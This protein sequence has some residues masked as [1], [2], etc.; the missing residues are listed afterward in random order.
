MSI[1]Q[2]GRND[3]LGVQCLRAVAALLVV[4]YHAVEQWTNHMP[5][6]PPGEYWPNGAAGVDIFFVISGLVMTISVQRSAGCPHAAWAFSKN[7]IIR[8]VPLYWII[9]TLKIVAVIAVPALVSR[10]TLDPFYVAG[11]YALLPVRDAVGIIR[12][13]LPV[14]W[15]LSYE[16]FFYILIAAALVIRVPIMRV[17]AP[18]L[19]A[20]AALAF[21]LPEGGFTNTI[22]VE[23]IF[24]I[25]IGNALPRLRNVPP[26]IAA[27]IGSIAFALLVT[28]PIG[29]A[30][31]R[32]LTWGLPAAGIVAATVSAELSLRRWLP[33]WLLAAGN[34]SYATYLTHGF[35][36]PAAFLLVRPVSANLA[37]MILVGLT[38]SAAVG[39]VTHRL[40]EQPLLLSLRSRRPVSTL[41]AAG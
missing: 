1:L 38:V 27:V 7:R 17:C 23:F 13:V 29:D 24:G 35:V 5:G 20:F 33:R 37:A 15:T 11:S 30:L 3:L 12:P 4:A 34:A 19:L 8:I 16:M 32:P 28:V 40:I 2:E 10:T 18:L 39:H 21:F 31:A 41:P 36:I 25:L 6:Y 14:G 22:V 26:A 9:T